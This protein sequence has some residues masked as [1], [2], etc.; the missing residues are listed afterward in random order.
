MKQRV[1][2]NVQAE[3]SENS[4]KSNLSPSPSLNLSHIGWSVC[5][6]VWVSM[7]AGRNPSFGN[8]LKRVE[9]VSGTAGLPDAAVPGSDVNPS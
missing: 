6:R 7:A 1:Y 5:T 9:K 2:S 8:G 4:P 3:I